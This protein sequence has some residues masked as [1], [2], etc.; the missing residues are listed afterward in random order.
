M[1]QQLKSLMEI[2]HQSVHGH[3]LSLNNRNKNEGDDRT[4]LKER[5][6][7]AISNGTS[8][9]SGDDNTSCL[10]YVFGIRTA[11]HRMGKEGSR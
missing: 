5:L 10:E 6:K 1:E 8:G 3:N 11:N 4:R 2:D 9:S 7:K